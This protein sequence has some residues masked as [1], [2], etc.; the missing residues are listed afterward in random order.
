MIERIRRDI[1]AIIERV[2][3]PE[4]M[5]LWP[6]AN[7]G[8]TTNQADFAPAVDPRTNAQPVPGLTGV[9]LRVGLPGVELELADGQQALIGYEGGDRSR[10][11]IALWSPG[12]GT[13]RLR[14][15]T[16]RLE[17]AA[18]GAPPV[19]H[20]ATIEGTANFLYQV[21]VAVGPSL[22]P[23]L[24]P[25]QALAAILAGAS[26]AATSPP[27]PAIPGAISAAVETQT[28]KP[29]SADAQ[30]SPGICAK[31]FRTG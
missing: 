10:P 23:P 24:T 22:T 12:G 8:A 16:D 6:G 27:P 29:D 14:L 17:A 30:L 2:V 31:G 9:P 4:R 11:F 18:A 25:A 20:V 28:A 1:E 7:R 26:L 13:K 15:T 19:E 5:L 21:L 3:D